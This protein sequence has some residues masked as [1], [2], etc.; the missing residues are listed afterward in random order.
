MATKKK[1]QEEYVVK[2]GGHQEKF[3]E[4]KVYGSVY[5]AC[6]IV[7]MGEHDCEGI[8]AE[9]T[10]K[11]TKM[12]KQKKTVDSKDIQEKATTELKKKSKNAAFMYETHRD[13]S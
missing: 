7:H 13:V 1:K 11:V 12:V 6:N 10:K 2:R 5:A 3:D 9:V 8:A 4:K